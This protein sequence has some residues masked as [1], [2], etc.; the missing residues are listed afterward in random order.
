MIL[1][2]DNMICKYQFVVKLMIVVPKLF[3]AIFMPS[4]NHARF[5]IPHIRNLNSAFKSGIRVEVF[6][7]CIQLGIN[8]IDD[9]LFVSAPYALLFIPDCVKVTAPNHQVF[10]LFDDEFG[11]DDHY[12]LSWGFG[13]DF[14]KIEHMTLTSSNIKEVKPYGR[15]PNP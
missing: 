9:V 8:Q 11:V 6:L 5:R 12:A 4:V 3:R 14:E 15:P 1:F 2:N 10:A 13:C 7:I